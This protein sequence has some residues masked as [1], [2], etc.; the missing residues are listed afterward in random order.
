MSALSD[1]FDNDIIPAENYP[2]DF[3]CSGQLY[4]GSPSVTREAPGVGINSGGTIEVVSEPGGGE[5]ENSVMPDKTPQDMVDT[6]LNIAP[7]APVADYSG[8]NRSDVAS[9]ARSASAIA[10]RE[11]QAVSYHG[12]VDNAVKSK[13]PTNGQDALDMSVQVKGTHSHRVGIVYQ[14]SEFAILIKLLAVYFMAILGIGM[15]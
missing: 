11:Y 8:A 2:P 13:A 6:T 12:K 9:S 5:L 1:D 4:E 3:V 10:R 7:Q 15:T 14:M